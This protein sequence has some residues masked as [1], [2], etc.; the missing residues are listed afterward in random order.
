[1]IRDAE[2]DG[3]LGTRRSLPPGGELRDELLVVRASSYGDYFFVAPV[4]RR[5]KIKY[6][7]LKITYVHN[8]ALEAEYVRRDPHIDELL[9]ATRL[10]GD[11]SDEHFEVDEKTAA[12]LLHF[13]GDVLS[14]EATD[15]DHPFGDMK[16]NI[17][18]HYLRMA[19]LS[20]DLA[21]VRDAPHID[22][23]LPR[24]TAK[25]YCVIHPFS[26]QSCR[27]IPIRFVQSVVERLRDCFT[28]FV[29]V[30]SQQELD[31][32]PPQLSVVKVRPF[33]EALGAIANASVMF[34]AESCMMHV[35]QSL[36][37]PSVIIH[38]NEWVQLVLA[39][40]CTETTHFVRDQN[41]ISAAQVAQAVRNLCD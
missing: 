41:D 18:Q 5:L 24:L 37:V 6:P 19:G 35:A 28:T 31:S 15:G 26:S 23:K 12:R 38:A 7:S 1:M 40:Y 36:C 4:L 14:Y 2:I 3:L 8:G 17:F 10:P 30:G 9:L 13:K 11:W 39:P 34:C 27:S 20:T 21:G 32:L 22:P 29:I 16:H 25:P 33:D